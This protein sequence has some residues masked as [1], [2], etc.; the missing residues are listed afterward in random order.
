[1][2]LDGR[3]F[4][5]T[6][7]LNVLALAANDAMN[8]YNDTENPGWLSANVSIVSTKVKLNALA[9]E[10]DRRIAAGEKPNDIRKGNPLWSEIDAVLVPV[11]E[12]EDVQ[13]AV[14]QLPRDVG[15]LAAG[16]S[17]ARPAL[18]V[19]ILAGLGALGYLWARK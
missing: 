4:Y 10:D 5:A 15:E 6:E 17:W 2:V 18:V 9:L 8:E 14:S 3:Q 16:A 13:W 1:M 19:G 7:V 12:Y 11:Q